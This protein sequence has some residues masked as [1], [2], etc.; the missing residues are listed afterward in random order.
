MV[1]TT[2]KR[3]GAAQLGVFVVRYRFAHLRYAIVLLLAAGTLRPHL[4]TAQT[5]PEECFNNKFCSQDS[6][7]RVT[8]T[9]LRKR[10]TT[11]VARLEYE[12]LTTRM[13][14]INSVSIFGGSASLI[15]DTGKEVVVEAP[16][17]VFDLSPGGMKAVTIVF[18][19]VSEAE[20]KGPFDLVVSAPDPH[21]TVSFFDLDPK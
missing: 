13:L 16:V 14:N 10:G 4:S 7:L 18:R 21:G 8:I 20:I 6:S 11:V 15:D 1:Q 2:P 19:F 17:G 12:N 9:N 5:S 3:I